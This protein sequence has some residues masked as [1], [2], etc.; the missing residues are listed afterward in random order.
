M[1]I[2]FIE[3]D[4]CYNLSIGDSE[5]EKTT[6]SIIIAIML[7]CS[8]SACNAKGET[9]TTVNSGDKETQEY[10]ISV[11]KIEQLEHVVISDWLDEENAIVSKEN[12]TL[13]KM[14][15]EEY[16]GAYHE[17]CIIIISVPKNIHQLKRK[18]MCY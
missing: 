3:A 17:V 11:E 9:I 8:L 6:T 7:V 2:Y 18:R 15:I 1:I 10:E 14:T 4:V 13:G 5:N 12:N 16:E